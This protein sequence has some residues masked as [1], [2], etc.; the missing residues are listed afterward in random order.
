MNTAV[1][2]SARFRAVRERAGLS[3]AETAA[4]VGVSE[5]CVWDLETY[6]DDLMTVCSPVDLQRFAGAF[7]VP[8]GAIV[9]TKERDDAISAD[10]TATECFRTTRVGGKHSDR[11]TTSASEPDSRVTSVASCPS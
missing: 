7:S 1:S 4:R 10:L 9:G 11:P 6:D 8:P 2:T 5:P 3:I